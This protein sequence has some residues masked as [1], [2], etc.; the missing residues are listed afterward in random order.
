M[1]N[2]YRFSEQPEAHVVPVNDDGR[3]TP[4]ED[5]EQVYITDE[6]DSAGEVDVHCQIPGFARASDIPAWSIRQRGPLPTWPS[7]YDVKERRRIK[8][9]QA[10]VVFRGENPGVYP[11]W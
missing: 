10:Y 3:A 7:G 2:S 6:E 9:K 1:A 11:G 5:V 8:T 4:L